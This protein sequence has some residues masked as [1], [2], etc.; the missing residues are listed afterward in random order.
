MAGDLDYML[1]GKGPWRAHYGE[2]NF[3]DWLTL[4]CYVTEVKGMGRRFGRFERGRAH[5]SKTAVGNLQSV[6]A[7]NTDDCQTPLAQRGCDSGDSIVKHG[8]VTTCYIGQ[9]RG[10]IRNP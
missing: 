4:Q 5:R 9:G 6:G 10:E 2:Q 1:S 3:I 7:R 8:R